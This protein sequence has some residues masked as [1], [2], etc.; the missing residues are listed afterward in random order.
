MHI[1]GIT[2]NTAMFATGIGIHTIPHAHIGTIYLINDAFGLLLYVLCGLLRF[3]PVVNA[4]YMFPYLFIF[5]KTVF[6]I[7]LGSAAFLVIIFLLCFFRRN[8]VMILF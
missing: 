8:P 3:S 4:F 5:Q 6:C 2:I 7:D 1:T